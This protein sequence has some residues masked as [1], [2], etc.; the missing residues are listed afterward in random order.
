MTPILIGYFPKQTAKK[1]DWLDVPHVAEVCSVSECVSSGP[2]GWIDQWRHNA[3]WAYDS[4]ELAWSVVPAGREAEFDLYA[5]RIFPVRF[6]G[7]QENPVEMPALSVEPLSSA[8][9][10][11]GFDAVSR[12]HLDSNFECSPLSCNHMA[13]E[14]AVNHYCLLETEIEGFRV[15]CDFSRTEPEPGPYYLVEVWRAV[16]DAKVA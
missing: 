3:L 13:K 10:R 4:P 6:E 11:L 5:W 1:P 7:G 15:A 16:A 9:V 12:R 2:D 14:V 8:F